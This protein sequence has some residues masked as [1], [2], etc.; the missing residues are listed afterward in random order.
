MDELQ[1]LPEESWDRFINEINWMRTRFTILDQEAFNNIFI[2]YSNNG[3]NQDRLKQLYSI[4]V[5][6]LGKDILKLY[7]KYLNKDEK[8]IIFKYLNLI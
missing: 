5:Y 1:K 4:F 6:L 8:V 7:T 3:I 2:Q